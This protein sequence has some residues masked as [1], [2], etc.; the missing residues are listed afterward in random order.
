MNGVL[1]LLFAAGSWWCW[2]WCFS[3]LLRDFILVRQK[4]LLLF[5]SSPSSDAGVEDVPWV[6]GPDHEHITSPP[7]PAMFELDCRNRPSAPLEGISNGLLLCP[8]PASQPTYDAVSPQ[9]LQN[10]SPQA[11]LFFFRSATKLVPSQP[12]HQVTRV[13]GHKSFG[14]PQPA[15]FYDPPPLS[16]QTHKGMCTQDEEYWLYPTEKSNPHNTPSLASSAGS[17][18]RSSSREGSFWHLQSLVIWIH[19]DSELLLLCFTSH[20]AWTSERL[21]N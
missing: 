17:C 11:V 6:L 10:K 7:Q 9:F 18:S 20:L 21:K 13:P 5:L 2:S 3:E 14:E 8:P 16:H 19:C 15:S 1:L 12:C 4:A